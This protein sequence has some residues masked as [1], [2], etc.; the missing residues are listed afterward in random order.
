MTYGWEFIA[1]AWLVTFLSLG[2]Y[3]YWLHRALNR[4]GE[5]GES[6]P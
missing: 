3:A 2:G 1:A 5:D 4:S 6:N